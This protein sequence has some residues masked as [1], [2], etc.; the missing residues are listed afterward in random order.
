M[1]EELITDINNFSEKQVD[2]DIVTQEKTYFSIYNNKIAQPF[3]KFWFNV[4]NTKF[5]RNYNDYSVLYF[6]LNNKSSS[7]LKL[8]G[9]I[10][11]LSEHLKNLFEKTFDSI[12]VDLPWK[13]YESYPYLLSFYTNQDIIFTDSDKNILT[14]DKLDTTQSYSLLFEI[15]NVKL[16]KIEL[17]DITSYKLK[18][19]LNI[20][21]IQQEPQLNLK[22][23]LLSK[24]NKQPEQSIQNQN[25]TSNTNSRPQ[26]PFLSQLSNVVLKSESD[27]KTDSND[28][29]K[30]TSNGPKKL[31]DLNEILE[32]KSRLI[33]V[34]L[35]SEKN[36]DNDD[37][38]S[39]NKSNKNIDL[40]N[41]LIEQKNQL[42][43]VKTKEKSLLKHLKKQS[44]KKKKQ[45]K[46]IEEDLEKELELENQLVNE[47]ELVNQLDNQLD[48]ELELENELTN[49]LNQEN[50]SIDINNKKEKKVKKDKKDKKDKKE[51]KNKEKNVEKESDDLE[52]ELEMF[53]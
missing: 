19:N 42:K 30:S 25:P 47:H 35:E 16:Y 1:L 3:H 29:P 21:M 23:F 9:F 53:G 15:K 51:K 4:P 46:S 27:N 34:N 13:E 10:K 38:K 39:N 5:F 14:L 12:Q 48:N 2:H 41:T 44:K 43:K 24:I 17:D 8:I 49:E 32:I 11:K 6:A 28:K 52:K 36:T 40:E 31:I 33:K 20:L 50:Q 18:Y 7:V 37:N 22:S 26:L 45:S